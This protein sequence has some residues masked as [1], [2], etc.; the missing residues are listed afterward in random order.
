MRMGMRMGLSNPSAGV[1]AFD[2]G[3][4]TN[5]GFDA[6]PASTG[7]RGYLNDA[8]N[9]DGVTFGATPTNISATAVAKMEHATAPSPSD[10]E[11]FEQVVDVS[12]LSSVSLSGSL[13]YISG[14]ANVRV[15]ITGTGFTTVSEDYIGVQLAD[16][17]ANADLQSMDVSGASSI[18]IAFRMRANGT[19]NAE[20]G[21]LRL[22]GS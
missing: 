9:L 14:A 17:S 5:G 6:D 20:F 7:W 10:I 15:L 11:G 16:L 18:T 3:L 2:G 19:I 1:A 8:T 21:K 12:G 4:L 13:D 22:T